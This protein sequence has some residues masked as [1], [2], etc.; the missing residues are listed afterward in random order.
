LV[1]HD[2]AELSEQ[3]EASLRGED[4]ANCSTGRTSSMPLEPVFV[5]SGMGQQW[6]AM[7][8]ELLSQEPAFRRAV[9]EVNELFGSLAGWSLLEKLT[10]D[11][12]A[13]QV[14]E[15]RVGQPA[16]FALQVGLAALWR[17]WGVEPAA[18]LGHS[19]GEMA[20]TYI[21]G[22]LS[23]EDAIRVTFHRSRLQYR[24]AGQGGMLAAGISR[25]EAARLVE[26]HPRAISIAAINGL[27]SI[28]LS[29]DVAVLAEIDKALNEADVFSRALQVDVPYH[30]LHRDR[31]WA[32]GLGTRCT[33]LVPERPRARAV[34]RHDRKADRCRAPGVPGDRRTSSSQA[35]H[36]RL[37]D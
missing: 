4:R 24:T 23:L 35:G 2:R 26:R 28:T 32:G 1:A 18:V 37:L 6:W 33:V 21:A 3:L 22:V 13:S 31:H 14:Q 9:E 17:S 34:P 5:C 25:E 27:R 16:I 36:S 19:A 15:T 29:G 30:S 10:A 12:T 20:A 7:G 11:E 8:R